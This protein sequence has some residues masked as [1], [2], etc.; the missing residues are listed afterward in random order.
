MPAEES[1]LFETLEILGYKNALSYFDGSEKQIDL[2]ESFVREFHQKA[3]EF[4][5]GSKSDMENMT[6]PNT[7]I[8]N[9]QFDDILLFLLWFL[10]NHKQWNGTEPARRRDTALKKA[11][12]KINSDLELMP[13]ISQLCN[14]SGVSERTLEYAFLEKF[15][16]S[17]KDYIKAT[18]LNKVR[19]E[20]LQNKSKD[21]K[22]STIALSYG[23]WHMGQFAADYKKWFGELPSETIKR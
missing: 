4:L 16:V 14:Y 20:L 2:N 15:R 21:C 22:I 17:P 8:H 18:K 1:F 12:D 7:E 23:F 3:G 9:F 19:A 6:N 5:N 10:E 13:T 11:I